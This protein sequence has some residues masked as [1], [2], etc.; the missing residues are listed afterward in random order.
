MYEVKVEP[1]FDPLLC[2]RGMAFSRLA[3]RVTL[4]Y[5]F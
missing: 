1:Q 3:S 5:S 2:R 4:R